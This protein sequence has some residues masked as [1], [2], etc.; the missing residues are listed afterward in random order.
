MKKYP[1]RENL[2]IKLYQY[3]LIKAEVDETRFFKDIV[4]NLAFI[5]NVINESLVE[6]TINRLSYLDRAILRIATYSLLVGKMEK[7]FIFSEMLELT[8]LYTDAG[9]DKQKNFN[10]RVLSNI[11]E[12]ILKKDYKIN[13]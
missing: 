5:D 6:Y 3:D 10:H 9:D 2:L 7:G 8:K 4:L 11:N 1:F 13:E 12:T